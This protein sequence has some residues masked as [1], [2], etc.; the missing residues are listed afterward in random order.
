MY[1]SLVVFNTLNIICRSVNIRLPNLKC[2]KFKQSGLSV[3]L[4]I[5][6][7]L[8]LKGNEG[9]EKC[10][11]RKGYPTTGKSTLLTHLSAPSYTTYQRINR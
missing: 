7:K 10:W 8:I 11:G 2:H 9:E 6:D 5:K 3:N 1:T 4:C